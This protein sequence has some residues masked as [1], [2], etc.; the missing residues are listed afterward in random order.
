MRFLARTYNKRFKRDKI[1]LAV[2]FTPFT[3]FSQ[4]FFACY[5]GVEAVEF[6][7]SGKWRLKYMFR[8]PVKIFF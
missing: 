6:L 7:Q 3:Y 4:Q 2:L 1:Q 5:L 8:E